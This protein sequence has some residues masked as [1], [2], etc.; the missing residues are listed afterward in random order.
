MLET[1]FM[2]SFLHQKCVMPKMPEPKP[3][4]E[5]IDNYGNTQ[6]REKYAQYAYELSDGDLDFVLTG[7]AESKFIKD[8]RGVNK[9]GTVDLGLYQI[10]NYYHPY[11]TNHPFYKEN[12]KFQIRE[13][14]RLYRGGTRFYGADVRSLYKNNLIIK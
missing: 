7:Y 5:I 3:Y 8:A 10:N 12:W 11:I 1:I 2:C 9:G 14:L 13:A 6:E 4:V